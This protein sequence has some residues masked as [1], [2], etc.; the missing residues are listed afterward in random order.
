MRPALS[1]K[2]LRLNLA[3]LATIGIPVP[4]STGRPERTMFVCE[5]AA[6]PIECEMKMPHRKTMRH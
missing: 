1:R 6:L 2:Q 3:W 4:A 5:Q